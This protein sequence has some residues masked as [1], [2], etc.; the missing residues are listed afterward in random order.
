MKIKEITEHKI[1]NNDG[2]GATLYN[3]KVDY[4]GLRVHMKPST[5]L[6]LAYPLGKEHDPELEK[7]IADGGS[8]GAP[9]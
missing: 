2:A 5:F 3:Q 1:D 6:A 8:I 7:Y 4:Y 9:F